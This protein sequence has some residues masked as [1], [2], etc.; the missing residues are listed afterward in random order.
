MSKMFETIISVK[1]VRHLE[2]NKILKE[3]QQ[4]FQNKYVCLTNILDFF[5]YIYIINV[6]TYAIDIEILD[7]QK[8]FNKVPH[9]RPL[10]ELTLSLWVT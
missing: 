10:I 5:H 1:L 8:A 2:Y 7:F 6:E 4:G 9:K 3:S